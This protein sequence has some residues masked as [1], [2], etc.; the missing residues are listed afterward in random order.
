MKQVV[1][2]HFTVVTKC[3]FIKET[4]SVNYATAD[5]TA[6]ATNDYVTASDTLTFALV[7]QLR[8]FQ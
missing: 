7:K 6:T 8:L 3:C 1:Q 2:R 5:G 4:V